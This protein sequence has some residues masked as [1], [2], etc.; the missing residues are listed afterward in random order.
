MSRRNRTEERR[1]IISE[2]ELTHKAAGPTNDR[3]HGP[4]HRPAGSDVAHRT[5]ALVVAGSAT[6]FAVLLTLVA[7]GWRPLYAV[8]QAIIDAFNSAV[9]ALPWTQGVLTVITSIGGTG[10]AW[11]A[12]TAAVVWLAIRREVALAG[13]VVLTGLGATAL[14]GGIKA[15]VDRERPTVEEPVAAAPGFSF[16]SG[17]SLGSAVTYGVLALVFLPVVPARF[18][19][20]AIVVTVAAVALIGISRVAL[21]V[22]YP[23]DVL[24]GWLLGICWIMLTAIAYRR[25][26]S[27]RGE[28]DPPLTEG[29]DPAERDN[30]QLAPEHDRPLPAGWY[31]VVNL[32]VAAVLI[33][34]A[35]V[36][37]GL[38]VT[39]S[40]TLRSLDESVARWFADI[41]SETLTDVFFAVSRIGD[42]SSILVVLLVTAAILF[43]TT[44]RWRPA[45]FL[46]VAV[47]GEVLLFLAISQV[48]GRTR[49]E[50]EHLTPGLPPTSSFPSGHVA[51]TTALY[52]A[53]ALLIVFWSRSSPRYLAA[54]IALGLSVAMVVAR[55]YIGVH[56]LTDGVASILFV[57]AWLAA[58]WWAVR[59]DQ[60]EPARHR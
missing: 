28:A 36:A 40:S 33:W 32:V 47:G 19:R 46:G 22:H 15:L 42:T 56:F 17:H 48:V 31:S 49:P 3:R 51:A 27:G 12:L 13:Y 57:V 44:G 29:L 50:V 20:T 37:A 11:I 16:P 5:S 41:R 9:S 8:D 59:P 26:R 43:A 55:L 34:G 14:T 10:I 1:R 38:W 18:R 52:G 21:G 23:S 24:G 30:L 53:I 35:F 6:L 7:T 54:V 58:C 60:D 2:R 25:W 4:A 45:L 39:S